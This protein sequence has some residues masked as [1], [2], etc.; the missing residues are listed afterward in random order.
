MAC[1]RPRLE[2]ALRK[3]IPTLQGIELV[4]DKGGAKSLHFVLAGNSRQPKVIPASLA[5]DGAMLVTAFLALAYGGAPDILFIEE[6]EN[7]LHYSLLGQ[8]ID[9]LRKISKGEVGDRPRQVIITTHSPL[10]LNFADPAEVVVCQRGENGG[11][12]ATPMSEV[13]NLDPLLKEFAPGELWYSRV[14]NAW[15]RVL[16]RESPHRR[17]RRSR[18]RPRRIGLSTPPGGR[19]CW[20]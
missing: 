14:K 10:L 1:A 19:C 13:P 18:A 20:R 11:T 8:M 6:P 3:A 4:T 17:R 7:G 15:S 12:V 9:L 16:R 5:S 2:K